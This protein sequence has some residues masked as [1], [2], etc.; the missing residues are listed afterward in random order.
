MTGSLAWPQE[1]KT[2]LFLS[3]P[4]MKTEHCGPN[5]KLSNLSR[6]KQKPRAGMDWVL[7]NSEIL[8][9]HLFPSLE[10]G[11]MDSFSVNKSAGCVAAAVNLV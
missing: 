3:K 5:K 1:T 8:L 9:F 7:D 2:G 4:Y 11:L 10:H 6:K